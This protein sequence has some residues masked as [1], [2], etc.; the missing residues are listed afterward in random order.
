MSHRYIPERFLP[1]KAIDILDEVGAQKKIQEES[2]PSELAELEKSIDELTEEKK[3]LVKNQNYE[4]AALIRDKVIALKEKLEIFSEYWKTNSGKLRKE[5]TASD[6][7][8]VVS[9]MSG[10]PVEELDVSQVER[11][12]NMEN[13]IHKTVVGQD[14]A[15]KLISSAVRRNKA[16]ISS[17]NR[18]I[19]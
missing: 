11:L 10:I 16:G 6:V 13:E 19:G 12:V 1:D 14:E 18:P 8:H 5:V 4:K 7:Y 3:L 17:S 15:I 9:Q 2:R